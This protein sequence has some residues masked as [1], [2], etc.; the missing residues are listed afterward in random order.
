MRPAPTFI[1]RFVGFCLLAF[2]AVG[3]LVVRTAQTAENANNAK[4]AR[5]TGAEQRLA[6]SLKY[7][8]SDELEGRGLGTKGIDKA[9]D[10][11]A[12]RFRELGLKTEIFDGK[13]FQEFT[14]PTGAKLGETNKVTLAGPGKKPD[15]KPVE[16]NLKLGEDFNPMTLSGS[17]KFDLPLVFVGYG[18]TDKDKGYD[19]YKGIDV[20]DKAVVILRKI[21]Q[22]GNPHGSFGGIAQRSPHAPFT[23]KVSNAFQHG[24]AAVIF[25]TDKYGQDQSQEQPR[26]AAIKALERLA[27]AESDKARW[28]KEMDK[29]F[30]EV[31]RQARNL[32]KN[33][34]PVFPFRH[35]GN[36]STSRDIP[37]LHC[38]RANIDVALKTALGK[39]LSAL[40]DAID[41]GPKPQSAA[42]KGWSIRGELSVTRTKANVKNVVGVL[43]GEGP[44]ADETIVVGAHY[45]HL[46]YG[47]EGSFVKEKA[48]HNG[49]D[50]NGSGT[51]ALLEVA[52][53]L[54]QRKTKLPRR[55][56]FIAFTAEERGLIGS[57]RY[58]KEPLY[59][60]DQTVAMLN[61]DM[62][63]RL[64]DNKLVVYGTGTAKTFDDMIEEFNKDYQFK[65]TKHPGGTGPSDHATFY[66]KKIPVFHF[67]TGTH[68]Q[69]HRP[70]DDF[71]LINLPGMVKVTQLV[72]Q[73]A[74]TIA[75]APERPEF[76][77]VKS[78][79]TDRPA[80]DRLYFGSIPDFAGDQPGYAIMGVTSGGPAEKAGLKS[81][82]VIVQLG[83]NKIGNLEDFDSALRKFK[84]GDKV[85]VVVKREG[86]DVKLEVVLDPPR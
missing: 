39:D 30:K 73:V 45:D 13:P 29:H 59:P 48:I 65:I 44:L 8:S 42:L 10:F 78:K 46:G 24:A 1:P 20:K 72:T 64:T 35:V 31:V 43:E 52:R 7:L 69:Y 9:A 16:L 32:W 14:V 82:D 41:K 61:M 33:R 58:V 11:I 22:Q 27:E 19:S 67:F 55:V 36:V 79:R 84:A 18:I 40:E 34:D 70:S 77:Q 17:G 71:D 83:E 68:K 81:G 54:S 63:G 21:P 66:A 86:K 51:A 57:A 47:G 50:D 37:V 49:A 15:A 85:P 28:E 53:Q 60:L 23:A 38:T 12:G 25:V 75:A 5:W 2:A 80:G 74:E 6:D 4:T 56:V 3:L 76:V 26:R 62:V